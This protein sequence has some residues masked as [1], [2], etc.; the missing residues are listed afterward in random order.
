MRALDAMGI[1][2]SRIHLNEGHA[3]LSGVERLRQYV[4]A[5]D[6]FDAALERVREETIFTTHTPVAAGNEGYTRDEMEPILSDYLDQ[7][8]FP[9]SSFYGLGRIDPANEQEPVNITPLALRLSRAANG[10]SRRHGQVAQTMWQ[11]LWSEQPAQRVSIGYVT[12]G[13]HT[14]TWM[15]PAM[16]G[17]L[18]G[19]LGSD[20]RE[21]IGDPGF[22]SRIDSIPDADLWQM[23]CLLRQS[24]VNYVRE[25]SIQD[26]LSRGEAPDYVEAAAR[27]FDPRVFTI[28]F[29]RRVA[30]YKRLYLLTRLP[31][32]VARLLGDPTLPIQVVVAGK[33]HPQDQEAKQTLSRFFQ[34]KRSPSITGR[35]VFLEDYDLHLAPRIVSGV[36]L[37]LNLPRPPLEASGTSGM[38]VTLNGGLNL[39]VLDGWWEEA[40][41]GQNG[42]AIATPEA[43][44]QAQDQ[45]DAEALL[46]LL[47]YEIIP[48]FYQRGPDGIPHNWVQR[49]KTAMRT[50]I[51]RFT[52]GRMVSEYVDG[53]YAPQRCD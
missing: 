36:D 50:L 12:N 8:G 3:A 30:T 47:E 52:A 18:D 49:V 17:L 53:M 46:A 40:Y 13:V 22:W 45:H 19:H 21:R 16:Q 6:S 51:P 39:S 41:D 29:A 9:R 37:W 10:V 2:P 48:L 24:L 32:R 7:L 44:P 26:R 33:A 34:L 5:G 14:A 43:D 35:V 15:S 42:W 1:R 4:A 38:K 20:W 11:P 25:R 27:V 28:G 31:E 23:R